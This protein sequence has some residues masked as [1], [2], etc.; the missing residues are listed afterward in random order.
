VRCGHGIFRGASGMRVSG[1]QAL[2]KHLLV[3]ACSV[4][5]RWDWIW[6]LLADSPD[7][8][9]SSSEFNA[10]RTEKHALIITWNVGG[11]S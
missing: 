10:A 9:A 1:D 6:V 4:L 5:V 8:T 7:Q 2:Q 3:D 11:K